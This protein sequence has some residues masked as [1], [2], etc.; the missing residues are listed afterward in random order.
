MS[1]ATV[2]D[3]SA[4]RAAQGT[5]ALLD[6]L[7][8]LLSSAATQYVSLLRRSSKLVEGL[9]PAGLF[10]GANACCAVPT[11]DCPPRC[12]AEISWE[13]CAC[14][15]Q[16]ATVTVKNTGTQARNFTFGAGSLGPAKVEV[17]PPAAQLAPGQA[18]TLQVVVPGNQGLKEGETYSTELLIRGAYE[19]CVQL[20]LRVEPSVVPQLEVA[21]GEIPERITELKWYRH[22]QCTDPCVPP[23]LPDDAHIDRPPTLGTHAN[24][25]PAAPAAAASPATAASAAPAGT[26]AAVKTASRVPA[27]KKRG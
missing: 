8:Q 22:W 16:R 24:A 25:A 19:Q 13:G 9:L 7:P 11:Q 5:D 23:R 4:S 15:P 3:L 2:R 18:V 21:Q 20:K 12:I 26:A 17:A 27:K 10:D 1:Q 6:S 14:E